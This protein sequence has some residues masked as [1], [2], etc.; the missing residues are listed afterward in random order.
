MVTLCRTSCRGPEG[1]VAAV[2]DR[3]VM[4]RWYEWKPMPSAPPMSNRDMV[5][6][7]N[8]SNLAKPY[9]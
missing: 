4:S 9:G 3:A 6:V 2:S 8:V 5:A 1:N 7:P